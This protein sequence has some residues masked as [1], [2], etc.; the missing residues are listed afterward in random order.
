[1]KKLFL[2][3]TLSAFSAGISN[4][5]N[6]I[7]ASGD[8][9]TPSLWSDSSSWDDGAIVNS[10]TI[11]AYLSYA[12]SSDKVGYV[13]V[14]GDYLVK[15]LIPKSAGTYHIG[16][17]DNSSLTIAATDNSL[18]FSNGN[19]IAA[20][21]YIDSGQLNVATAS[22][23]YLNSSGQSVNFSKDSAVS[24]SGDFKVRANMVENMNASVVYGGT[25]DMNGSYEVY[26]NSASGGSAAA[27]VSST[28]TIT[29][30]HKLLVTNYRDPG[31]L[32]DNVGAALEVYGKINAG[33]GTVDAYAVG[34]SEA[35]MVIK[36]GGVVTVINNNFVATAATNEDSAA[37]LKV[38]QGGTLNAY[39]F[40]VN[41][42]T[43]NTNKATAI[44]DGD[45]VVKGNMTVFSNTY[46][47]VDVGET[48]SFST[49]NLTVGSSNSTTAAVMNV[50]GG[51]NTVS[52]TLTVE[53]Y[54]SLNIT[55]GELNINS[56]TLR[57]MS[58]MK[59]SGTGKINVSSNIIFSYQT[60]GSTDSQLSVLTAGNS[61]TGNICMP[62]CAKM[63]VGADNKWDSYIL[64]RG[65]RTLLAVS[66]GTFELNGILVVSDLPKTFEL[67]V[68]D[69]AK[70]I[71]G[72]I[73]G[74][75]T[76][77]NGS[78]TK[79]FVGYGQQDMGSILN[80][81]E[82]YE[83]TILFKEIG[84]DEENQ[85]FL[86]SIRVA[87][88]VNNDLKFSAYDAVAGGYWLTTGVV[89][90]ASDFAVALGAFAL[91]AALLRRRK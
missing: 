18:F 51:V 48:G 36:N 81:T 54:S 84:T 62:E 83:K 24:V 53:N 39:N 47:R 45:L 77:T 90:E 72:S 64:A 46:G 20:N 26:G 88:Q 61:V 33:Y 9:S 67:S 60:D 91:A 75:V 28:G 37:A 40:V 16:I 73:N 31:T 52:N 35:A 59:V 11:P 29:T 55:G 13:S 87:G 56:L 78:E 6:T 89:P 50:A 41:G 82:F 17:N 70:L 25:V 57:T 30:S 80:L 21:I 76:N 43:F 34:N 79:T 1:M 66:S 2:Y 63:S 27:I 71:L 14:D 32:N 15:H 19:N 86:D 38:E 74:S 5:A 3:L 65:G 10:E 68:A 44:I 49:S 85:A 8:P 23:I 4:A 12:N 58:S 7:L 42:N 22:A 69:G